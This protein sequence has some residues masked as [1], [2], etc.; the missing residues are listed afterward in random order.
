M[1][2]IKAFKYRIYPT[3]AQKET[4]TRLFAQ[5]RAIYNLCNEQRLDALRKLRDYGSAGMIGGRRV[6]SAE[7][8]KRY[9]ITKFDQGTAMRQAKKLDEWLCTCPDEV[10]EAAA[11]D[12]D[13]AWQGFYKGGG[14]PGFRSRDLNNSF[15]LRGRSFEFVRANAKYSFLTGNQTLGPVKV[16][17]H[18]PVVGEMKNVTFSQ[19][20]GRFYVSI[21]TRQAD[22]EKPAALL[23]SVGIDRGVAASI[24]TSD[25]RQ[26]SMPAERL[27]VLER[28]RKAVQRAV[29]RATKG[30]KRRRKTRTRLSTISAKMGRVRKQFNNVQSAKIAARFGVVVLEALKIRNMTASAKGTADAPGRNVRAKAGLNRAILGHNWYQ[31][32]QMLTYKLAWRGGT[33]SMVDPR[34][35]SQQCAAC[36][37]IDAASRRSQSVF[38]CTSCGHADNADLNAAKVIKNRWCTP[39]AE[40]PVTV[41]VKREASGANAGKPTEAGG[42]AVNYLMKSSTEAS[43]SDGAA[44]SCKAIGCSALGFAG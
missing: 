7:S 20:I 26:V 16:R 42:L 25:G 27:H 12:L 43:K 39:G 38:E 37:G 18:R 6:Y 5:S 32:E 22:L 31:F 33:L 44:M 15:R 28:R 1:E 9:S 36:G 14:L 29:S 2:I 23:R 21:Q 35:T 30:S 17:Q 4:M 34:N 19:E 40:R 41:S 24:S 3:A 13:R 11:A 10:L 8:K